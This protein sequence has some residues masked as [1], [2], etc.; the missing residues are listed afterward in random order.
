MVNQQ[1]GHP[2]GPTPWAGHTN[3]TTVEEI[4]MGEEVLGGMFFLNEHPVIILSDSGASRDFIS[5]T[6]AK[7]AML[8]I[9]TVEALYVISALEGRVNADRIVRKAPL[10]LAGRVFSTDLII[11][12]GQGL[13]VILGM[14]WMKLHRAVLDI[15]GRLVHLDSPVYG[16]VILHLPAVSRIK[17]S[18]HHMGELKLEDIHVIREF[19][20]VFPNNLPGMPPERAIEFKIELQPSTALI[21]KGLYK[22]SPMEMKELKIQLQGLLD[23]GYI[24]PSTSPWGCSALFMEKKDKELRLCVDYR[25]L[26]AVTIKN[27]YPLPCIDILFDQL[28]GAQVFSK[29]DLRSGYHQIK[30]RDEDIPKTAFTTRYGLYEYPVMSFGLTNAL[31]HFMYLM[32]LVFMPEL[33]QFVV[34]FID[35][36][37]VYLMSSEEHEDHL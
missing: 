28:A 16:K 12:K 22:M 25:P 1:R 4:P 19:L 23:K 33:D 35:Y 10:E 29:I 6:C 15:A 21:A 8:S 24:H 2:K 18:L 34:V 32:N 30:I 17:A 20:D 26:N 37:L 7:K 31:A 13:D 11:L 5:S 27:K 9:V 3:Y 36:V 14:S